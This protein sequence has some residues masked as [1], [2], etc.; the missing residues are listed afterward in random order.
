MNSNCGC[1]D[2]IFSGLSQLFLLRFTSIRVKY[3][4]KTSSNIPSLFYSALPCP[5][6]K[7]V[8]CST[9]RQSVLPPAQPYPTLPYPI[10]SCS[11]MPYSDLLCPFPTLHYHALS[12]PT[13]LCQT[14]PFPSQLYPALPG[15]TLPCPTL[16]PTLL[17]TFCP[18]QTCPV[19]ASPYSFLS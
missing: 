6:H 18:T 7:P 13:I 16:P 15:T 9:L 1:H 8:P 12:Y 5:I 4:S 14:L 2:R 19:A 11:A 17:P 3:T 10:L